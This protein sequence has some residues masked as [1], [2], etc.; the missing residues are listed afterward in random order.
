MFLQNRLLFLTKTKPRHVTDYF[1]VL[2]PTG[3]I[4]PPNG[5]LTW[6]PVHTSNISVALPVILLIL[7]VPEAA[8]GL[9]DEWKWRKERKYDMKKS[10]QQYRCRALRQIMKFSRNT[11]AYIQHF[12]DFFFLQSW[13]VG[14][15]FPARAL[16]RRSLPKWPKRKDECEM[17]GCVREK[18]AL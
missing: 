6:K 13:Q 8:S 16:S 9:P 4:F 18:R 5:E 10:W 11:K 1:L 7:L 2:I 12:Q 15:K 3:R 17:K 14:L